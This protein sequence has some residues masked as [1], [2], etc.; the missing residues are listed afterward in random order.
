MNFTF[1]IRFS[2]F[3]GLFLFINQVT[4]SQVVINPC[5]SITPI[6]IVVIGS[7]TAAGAGPSSSDSTWVNRY[8]RYLQSINPANQVT[9]LA[10]GGTTTYHIM[11]GWFATPSGKPA[12]TPAK[13]IS[14]A[15][16]LNPDAI[17]VNMPSNDA[18]NGFGLNEQMSNFITLFNEADTAGVELWV[19]TTQ[20]KNTSTSQKLIQTEVRDSILNYFG[21]YS[22][23][24]WTTIAD[25]NNG[26]DPLYNSGDGTHLNNAGHRILN[27]RVIAKGIPNEIMD[28]LSYL[29]YVLY[30]VYIEN[31]SLCGDSSTAVN[32]VIAN[33]GINNANSF[34]A[35]LRLD[36][37]VTSLSSILNS[38]ISP[39]NSCSFDTVKF[40]VNTYN[41]V[42]YSIE[43]Y[44]TSIDTIKTNDTVK[45]IS[46]LTTGHPVLFT[47]NDTVCSGD[48]GI[49]SANG[50]SV[51][52][53]VFWYDSLVGGNIVGYGK[54]LSFSSV[55]SSQTYYPEVVRGDLFYKNSLLTT[56]DASTNWNGI[57]FNI[58]AND[59]LTIDSLKVNIFS[60]G[61]QTIIG[62]YRMDSYI[63][64]ETSSVGWNSWGSKV[65]TVA[66]AGDF[67]TVDFSAI[68]LNPNDTL[69]VYLYMMN[70]ASSLSYQNSGGGSDYV[71]SNVQI[72]KGTGISNSYGTSYYPRNFSGEVFYHYGF[73]PQ[74]ECVS[75]RKP[76][77]MVV[78]APSVNLGNDTTVFL[79][80]SVLLGT[81]VAGSSYLWSN[82]HTSSQITVDTA[83]FMVGAN[84][85]WVEVTDKFGCTA[86]DTIVV[87]FSGSVSLDENKFSSIQIYPNPS[88]NGFVTIK[89]LEKNA[90]IEV[91]DVNGKIQHKELYSNSVIGL[92]HLSK[93]IYF[94]TFYQNE[95]NKTKKLVLD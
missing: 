16:S 17:I 89:G 81:Q 83:N 23:D 10:V 42:D 59:T 78:S 55:T 73:R 62:L 47:H 14:M 56:T 4:L 2:L 40:I 88:N 57:M 18:A 12:I 19:C 46:I 30:D 94:V 75:Q 13:N 70:S 21:K 11:P 48:S 80:Q 95:Q 66:S 25:T 31:Y 87:T 72:L 37:N 60:T 53:T 92:T 44:L 33:S 74:G 58:V 3:V 7:S 61:S 79:N 1:S 45:G 77:E 50:N 28:T 67:K 35:N 26:I 49:I 15:L 84:T 22:I 86:T 38:N 41:A 20:P 65:L 52:D 24:F 43:A 90:L 9:N 54:N 27:N 39:V 32:V 71:D 51:M 29:D 85:I 5:A 69:G 82:S 6:H 63:G 34:S 93:G 91:R 68:T 36:D 64:N 8:R 76:V